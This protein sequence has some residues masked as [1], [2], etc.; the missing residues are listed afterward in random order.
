MGTSR[1]TM[2]NWFKHRSTQNAFLGQIDQPASCNPRLAKGQNWSKPP[3][4]QHF[5]CFHIKPE[6]IRD[7]YQPLPS[8][9]QGW[10]PWVTKTK[11]CFDHQNGLEPKSL[12][13]FLN[14]L[15]N[16]RLWVEVGLKMIE[17]SWKSCM[18]H[19]LACWGHNFWSDHCIFE[20]SSVLKTRHLYLPIGTKT[21]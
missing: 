11:F 2:Y 15:S 8:L 4:K 18:T 17:I 20:M 6:I 21:S 10:L 14:S 12:W 9:T 5:S 13:K 19:Q 16:N 7:F 1:L 3:P